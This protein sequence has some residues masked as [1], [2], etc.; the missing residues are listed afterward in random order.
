MV[1][2]LAPVGI[3]VNELPE[4]M[5]PLFTVMAGRGFI[6][7]FNVCCGE[8]PQALLAITVNIPDE[9]GVADIV[10]VVELP[11]QPAGIV[12]VYAVAPLTAATE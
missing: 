8:L 10:L 2:V 3:M 12:Q 11:L 5:L 1:Y 9:P 6:V 4:Q 7:T